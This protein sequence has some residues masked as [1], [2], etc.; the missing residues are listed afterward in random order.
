MIVL[1]LLIFGSGH[2]R[3]QNKQDIVENGR[4]TKKVS[5]NGA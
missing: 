2:G 1:I 3:D 5:Q 4:N